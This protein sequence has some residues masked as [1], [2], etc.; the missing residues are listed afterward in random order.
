MVIKCLYETYILPA[1]SMLFKV[2]I[3]KSTSS[4]TSVEGDM[5]LS[6]SL[7]F[8]WGTA[9]SLQELCIKVLNNKPQHKEWLHF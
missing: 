1:P 6:Q 9:L 2:I 7:V 8:I 5:H 4:S 3:F